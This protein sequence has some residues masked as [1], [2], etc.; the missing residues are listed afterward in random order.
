MERPQ[1]ELDHRGLKWLQTTAVHEAWRQ[2]SRHTAGLERL[3]QDLDSGQTTG[4]RLIGS[5]DCVEERQ[6]AQR[7]LALVDELGGDQRRALLLQA[8]GLSS[9][10][11]V[12]V[13]LNRWTGPAPRRRALPPTRPLRRSR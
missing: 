6:E 12:N 5:E 9:S 13:E 4:E 8:A 2:Y 1:I 11:R 7:R 10:S 3:D